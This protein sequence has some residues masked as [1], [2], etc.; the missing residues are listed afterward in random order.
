MK[1]PSINELK[2]ELKAYPTPELIEFCVRLA[3]SKKETK[4]LL[5]YLMFEAQDEKQFVK[6]IQAE[7]DQLFQAINRQSAYTTKKGLQKT[8]RYLNRYIRY[9]EEDTTEIEL[10]IYFCKKIKTEQIDLSASSVINN[11]YQREKEKIKKSLG[12]LHEDLQYDYRETV[13]GLEDY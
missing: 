4:E 6:N 13:V 1:T 12:R 2:K 10:R 11:I 9:S 7:V 8:V 3:K 5:C